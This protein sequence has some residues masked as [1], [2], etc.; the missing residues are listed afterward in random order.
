ML[1][2]AATN[3]SSRP[4]TRK[5]PASFED[6]LVHLDESPAAANALAYAEALLP[7]GNT[8]ALMF[9]LLADYPMSYSSEIPMDAWLQVQELAK[10]TASEIEDRLKQ[11]LARANSRAELRRSDVM[12]GEAGEAIAVQ[13]RYND[14]TV[15]GWPA[16][17]GSGYSKSL[18]E[19]ALFQSGRPVLLIPES[20]TRH[21]S[22]NRVLIA[23]SPERESARAVNDA[24]PLL[25]SAEQVRILV[26]DTGSSGP[27]A[28]PG[29]DM[30]RH[31]A[32]HGV[33]VEVKHV[34]GSGEP[35]QRIILK[36]GEYLG[37]DLIVMGGYGHS[38]T[39]EWLFG[40]VTRDILRTTNL[41]ILMSH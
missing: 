26:V 34:P 8:T 25:Q 17:T 41:P 18:F 19:A 7:D 14:L 32:R 16:G 36:E 29:D 5:H 22:P 15:I 20:F 27:E 35:V 40:G 12:S 11:K 3:K 13:G 30:A 6:I 2:A 24:L 28:N 38:R 4:N 39:G 9:G 10:Q 37:A 23:W 31:L 33:N 21:G 1:H